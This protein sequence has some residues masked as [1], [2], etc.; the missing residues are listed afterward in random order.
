M[1]SAH[2]LRIAVVGST[3][4]VG[5]EVLKCLETS[6]LP[7][8][9][10]NAIGSARSAGRTLR[11]RE[12]ELVVQAPTAEGLDGDY[13]VFCASSDVSR[14]WSPVAQQRGAIVVDNSSAFRLDPDVPLVVPEINADRLA[15]HRGLVANPN[16][17]AAIALMAL[18]PLHRHN[19][20]RRVN[21]V[22][23]QA[24]SGAGAAA[25]AE[26]V[27]GTRAALED[28]AFTPEVL[29]HPSAFNVFSHNAA[30]DPET[31]YNGEETKVRDE[32]RKILDRPDLRVSA[33]CMRVPVLR[34]HTEAILVECAEPAAVEDIRAWYDGA[35]GVRLI[36]DWQTNTFPMPLTASGI[37]DVL[38]GR[39][40]RDVSDESG[41]SFWL[42]A[43]GDQ[44]RKGAALNAVQIVEHLARREG[45]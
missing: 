23:Y 38:V 9:H 26:L 39:I 6:D 7:I 8:A 30:V 28:R 24:A 41:R 43:A 25:M 14:Q 18:W 22:T 33:T 40:R 42:L 19:P 2:D 29:P 4:A 31:L 10:V 45:G 17:S 44:L 1:P 27:A 32:M 36:D 12:R 3:G 13:A 11:F 34:A 16:C 20:L 35:A 37:D 5:Q 21:I 15:G